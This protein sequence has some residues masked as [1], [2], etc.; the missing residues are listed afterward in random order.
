MKYSNKTIA[1]LCRALG[2]IVKTNAELKLLFLEFG[3]SYD[4]FGGGI[5][6]H[7]N[8]LVSTLSERSDADDAVARVMEYDLERS[9]PGL[10]STDRLLQLLRIDGFEW[11]NGKLVPTTPQ[12]AALAGELSQLERDLQ[13][14]ML[15]VATEHYRQAHES[16]SASNWEAANSQIRP[17]MENLL[18]ELGKR[19]ISKVRSDPSAALQD[20]RDQGFIDSPEWQMIRGYWQGRQDN[21]P[22]TDWYLPPNSYEGGYAA[23]RPC[24]G[25]ELGCSLRYT[26]AEAVGRVR[27]SGQWCGVPGDEGGPGSPWRHPW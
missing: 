5:Q 26:H 24:H 19:E 12:P 4:Q 3:L 14:L 16:F 17:F 25:K 13:D 10:A 2:A 18:I 22:H 6:P 9:Y 7:S 15:N 20:L 11:H 1:E 27:P 8:A 23:A 21:G